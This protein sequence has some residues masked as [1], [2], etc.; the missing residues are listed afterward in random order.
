MCSLPLG[1][2]S[3]R[4]PRP[5]L[6]VIT[7]HLVKLPVSHS[8]FPQAICFTHGYVYV[9]KLLF[10]FIPALPFPTVSTNLFSVSA[11]LFLLCKWVHQQHFSRF[12]KYALINFSLSDLTSLCITGS[13]FIHLAR[14]DSDS[15]LVFFKVFVNHHIDAVYLCQ[16]YESFLMLISTCWLCQQA[17][18]SQE[19]L[20]TEQNKISLKKKCIF[21]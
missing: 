2:P 13:R 12:H 17:H 14:T 11:S 8:T 10:Q 20:I 21:G 4:I 5:P 16:K 3:H 19:L 18:T 7:G 9:S 1:L 15:Q 6:W